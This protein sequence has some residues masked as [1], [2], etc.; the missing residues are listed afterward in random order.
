R[1]SVEGG[2]IPNKDVRKLAM[3][4]PPKDKKPKKQEP[5]IDFTQYT[6]DD[7]ARRMLATP[8]KPKPSKKKPK[9]END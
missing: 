9:I 8:P 3:E 7:I 2:I 1:S 5:E 4:K 6:V